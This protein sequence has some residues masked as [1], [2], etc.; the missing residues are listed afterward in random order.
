[1][2]YSQYVLLHIFLLAFGIPIDP[3]P[4]LSVMVIVE[5]LVRAVPGNPLLIFPLATLFL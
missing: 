3:S 2:G 1:M 4:R 5:R